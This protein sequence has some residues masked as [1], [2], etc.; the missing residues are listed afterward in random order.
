MAQPSFRIRWPG[1]TD[2]GLAGNCPRPGM[3]LNYLMSPSLTRIKIRVICTDMKL[4]KRR[5]A[6]TS[7]AAKADATKAGIRLAAIAL[8]RERPVEDFTL[9]QVAERAGVAVRTILRAYPSK[10]ELVYAALADMAAGGVFVKPSPPGDVKAA[11]TAFFDIYEGVGDLV[12]Q[13]LNDE[14][15]HPGLKPTLDQGR[16][17]HRD[18]VK[19][20]FAPQL[21]RLHGAARKELLTILIILTDVYVWKLLRRDMAL[22]RAAAEATVRKMITSVLEKETADGTD[23]VAELV[24][25]RK[26]AA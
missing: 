6:M 4:K 3:T 18:G 7:R 5:Y 2:S 11:V 20:V 13:W 14:R 19:T 26:P 24:G 25:R 17:N 15:R 21:E 1:V 10:D 8:Y 22:S 12:M 23:S 16:D 9:E